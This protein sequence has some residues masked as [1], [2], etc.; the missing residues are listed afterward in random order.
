MKTSFPY[1]RVG[2]A[3]AVPLGI[4][5][6]G[7]GGSDYKSE[8]LGRARI[9]TDGGSGDVALWRQHALPGTRGAGWHANH[10][11]LWDGA[12]H[13]GQ[14]LDGSQRRKKPGDTYPDYAL[15]LGSHSGGAVFR[16]AVFAKQRIQVLQFP[17]E[18]PGTRQPEASV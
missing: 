13:A 6:R 4:C 5:D 15:P 8:F 3:R 9:H 16:A 7:Y 1:A 10:S 17:L 18:I 14:P 12:A 11:G 2:A